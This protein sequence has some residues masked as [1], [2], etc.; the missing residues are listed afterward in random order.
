MAGSEWVPAGLE[1]SAA[2]LWAE[3]SQEVLKAYSPK[4]LKADS[5]VRWDAAW[6]DSAGRLNLLIPLHLPDV[7]TSPAK[8]LWAVA[9]AADAAVKVQED[10]WKAALAWVA[11]SPAVLKAELTA[12]WDVEWEDLA[13]RAW[14]ADSPAALA[15]LEV[16]EASAVSA[17][18][19]DAKTVPLSETS[20]SNNQ[21]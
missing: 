1:V 14:A 13:V 11:D 8:D 21:S 19:E 9:C 10:R 3:V 4:V 5:K 6:A 18:L 7:E 20:S 16:L 15:G 17:D 2:D 12:P